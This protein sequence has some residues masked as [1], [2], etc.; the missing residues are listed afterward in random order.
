MAATDARTHEVTFCS[1]VAS[2]AKEIFATTPDLPFKRVEIE[3]ST[4]K[5]RKR[6]DLRVY[7]KAQKL[8]LAGEVKMPGTIEGRSP[9]NNAVVEDAYRKADQAQAR[10][11]FTWNVNTLVLFDRSLWD[12]SL[13][14][15]KLQDWHL[16][17][18][19]QNASDVERAEVE[20]AIQ[21][22]LVKFFTDFSDIVT[23][24][25]S[26]WAKAPDEYF[27]SA[28]ESHI[29]WPVKLAAE[30]LMAR[31]AA[32]KGFDAHLQEW[33]A[34]EQSW[35]VV[36]KN[37][38]EW[39][40]LI[41]RVARTLCY[42]FANRLIF[43]ESVR[44]K[45]EGLKKLTLSASVK[46]AADLNAYFLRAFQ[47]AVEVSG[48][49]ETL[50]YP[51][52][53]DW[54]GPLIFQHQDAVDAWRSVLTNLQPFDFREI[55]SDILGGIFKRLIDPEERHKFGQHY[56]SE[57]LVDVV[58]AFC[59]RKHNAV[60]LDPACGSGSFLVRA[61]HRK[62]LMDPSAMHQQRLREIYGSDVS[63]FAAHLATLNLAARDIAE[64]ENYPRI[65]RRN[66]F[67]VRADKPFCILP[68]GFRDARTREAIALPAMDAIVGNPPYVR[69]EAIPRRNQKGVK[70]MQAKEDLFALCSR[71][72]PGLE[73][74]GRSDFH[75]YF[76]PHAA[77]FLREN[78]WFGFLVSSSWL[79]VE[80][81][82]ALQE[83][84]LKNFLIH[85]ILESTAEPWF[86]DAR[87][88]TCAVIMQRCSN[89]TKRMQ[90]VVKFV[91]LTAKLRD[92]LGER[93]DE[94]SRQSAAEKFRQLIAQTKENKTTKNWRIIVKSQADLWNEG[95]RV[96]R[97]FELQ[98]QREA[99]ERHR[100]LGS[101]GGDEAEEDEESD[102]A[103]QDGFA[104][105]LASGYGGGK[106][107]K[108]LRAPDL[109]FRIM[110]RYGDRFVQFG[111]IATI[112][113]GVKSGCD[114]F[115]MPRDVSEKFLER[116]NAATWSD[117]P[118]ITR[119]KRGEVESGE[120]KLVEAGDGT[121]H[122]IEAKYLAP[123]VHSLMELNRPL[124]FPADLSRLI[125]LVSEPLPALRGSHVAKYLRYGEATSFA[126]TKSKAVPVPER[127]TCAGR[128]PWYDLTYTKPGHLVWPKSQQY[129]HIVAYN[130]NDVIV[131]CNLYDVT[132]VDK[133][134]RRPE[135]VAAMLNSTLIALFKIYF[136]RY[137]GTEGNLKTEVVDVNLLE[138]P[139]PQFAK[140]K[141]A[142]K[143][144]DAFQRLCQRDTRPMVEE[145]FTACR[146][147]ERAEQMEK[148]P[149]VLP[150]ELKMSDRRDLDLAVFELIGVTEPAEREKL[151]DELYFETAKH[152]RHTRVVEIKKQEQRAK[153]E[154]REFRIEELALDLWDALTEEEK[155]R[156][157]DWLR[158]T[159]SPEWKAIIPEGRPHL[160]DAHDMLEA[161]TVFFQLRKAPG[162]ERPVAVVC[163]SRA[164]AEVIHRLAGLGITD[165]IA[166][167]LKADAVR[168]AI[169]QRLSSIQTRSHDLARSRTSDETRVDDLASLLTRWMIH[170]RPQRKA[171]SDGAPQPA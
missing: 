144:K 143:L 53:K 96:A 22:F 9:Y 21:N 77:S 34:R 58:N 109:Y 79:D 88:K 63:V 55:R 123:E 139:D 145:E 118:I 69:Q 36:R 102:E 70:P 17:L 91:R 147:S 15:K 128:E 132:V 170:G 12:K 32:D 43:Y 134:L 25:R 8:I 41:D 45:F 52:A 94:S 95:L 24:A 59:I 113:F 3:Q 141:V 35:I 2:W 39:R 42:V 29:A 92:I 31:C 46:T 116:Y 133:N 11:F 80:Y 150:S 68:G 76:W 84:V 148:L 125:L 30:Y 7:D 75:C 60:V 93:K 159:F 64:E 78:G 90:N 106:W 168:N 163:P 155:V 110:E 6:S 121:V 161:T 167:P 19:L 14:E 149:I 89:E 38:E 107:G 66:F 169:E 40:E 166:L 33:M 28:F 130:A 13:Y 120:V 50:F 54:A 151:C 142:D 27:I 61:Y 140:P 126:S 171:A 4:A 18:N 162:A 165:E 156:L 10:F 67:E 37:P 56:T 152:F 108:Y 73:L 115:F 49:Y 1:R 119:C 72:W 135:I 101:V 16:G 86:S 114:A 117:A 47:R 74:S 44:A 129:R 5:N 81:G 65:A 26:D 105:V 131:N 127:S 104:A 85:A 112:R 71:E 138:V 87:V 100:S 20:T 111:E 99:T 57:D 103:A 137:A 154:G 51:D 23:G 98:K 48:D 153:T 136:G 158:Q 97:L 146:S 157:T 160:P 82:F 62:A 83:W 124:I 164:H 122:P